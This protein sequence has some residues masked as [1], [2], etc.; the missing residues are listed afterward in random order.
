MI[1]EQQTGQ[2]YNEETG[3]RYIIHVE[4]FDGPLDL[5][6]DLIKRSRM[7]ITEV[8]LSTITSQY[9]QH[10]AAMKNMNVKVAVEFIWMASELIYYKSRT[11]LPSDEMEDEYFVPPLPPELIEKLLE[12]KKFQ[13]ASRNLLEMYELNADAY[14]RENDAEKMVGAEDYIDVSLFDLLK[15]FADVMESQRVIEKEEIVFDEVLVSDRISTIT[16]M[17]AEKESVIFTEIFT[18]SRERPMII[19][20]FLAM[21]EMVKSGVIRIMQNRMY[22]DIRLF[23]VFDTASVQ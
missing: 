4:N 9:C 22:G 11:L 20:T 16:E 1:E 7:D 21:L 3:D 5:L 17:L 10:L 13:A 8:S 18:S 6:W 14:T 19:A 12:Y 15:A 2:E 23:R